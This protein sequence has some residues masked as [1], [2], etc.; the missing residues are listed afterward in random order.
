M[1]LSQHPPVAGHHG[2][3]AGQAHTVSA[4]HVPEDSPEWRAAQL[5]GRRAERRVL[6]RLIEAVRAGESRAL[7]LHGEAGVGKTALLEYLAAQA[8]GCRIARTVNVQSEMELAFAGLH[9]LCAPMLD[10]LEHLPVP[11]RDALRTAFGMSPGPA[12]DR[13]LVGLAV[14]S[15][16]SEVAEQQPLVCLVD[17]GQWLDHASAQILAFVARRLGAESIGLVFAER[18]RGGDLAGLPEL[19]VGGLQEADARALLDSALTG[20]LDARVRDQIIA[21][22]G[23]NPLA[24]LELPRGLTVA[25][26]AG[27]FGFPGAVPLAGS[28]EASFR[29]RSDALPADSRRLLLLAAADPTGDSALLWRAAERLGIGGEAAA[30]AAEAGLAEF[31]VRVRFR[32]PLVRSAA[33]RSASTQERQQ[34]HRALAEATDPQLDP[35]RRAWHRAQAAPG[36]DEDVAGELERSAG[37][38]RARGGLAAA[39][40]FL[41]R[42]ATLTLDPA[43]RAGRALAAAQAKLQAGVLDVVRDLLAMAETGPLSDFQQAHLDL[44]WAQ[45][46]LITRR[47]GDAPALLLKAAS[48]LA[49]IDADL[50]RATYLD[51]LFAAISAGRLASPGGGILEVARAAGAAP[52]PPHAPRAPDLLLDGLAAEYNQGYAAAVP[53]LRSALTAYAAGMS[54]DEELH[55]LWLAAVVA[56]RLWDY[57]RWDVLSVRHVQLARETGALSELPLALTSRAYVLLF[58]GELTAAASLIEEVQAVKEATGTGLAPYGPLGLAALRGDEAETLALIDATMQDVTRRGE[59]EGITFA[60]WADAV[61]SNGLG[62]YAKAAAAARRACSFDDDLGSLVWVTPELTEAAARTGMTEAAAWACDRLEEMTSASGT[63]WGLGIGAR[64]RALVSEG[65]EAERLYRESIARLGRTRLR[66]DL[67][68]AQLLYGEWLRRERRPSEAR[69]QLRTAH[70]MLEAMGIAAFAERARRELRAAGGTVHKRT[71]AASH[72]ELT[73]QEAQI[74]RLARDGLSN[75]EIGTRLFISARTV[76]YHLRKVFTKLG[77]TSRSQLDRVLPSGPAAVHRPR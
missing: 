68:R 27:G 75:P 71:A 69:E 29:W 1:G 66:V 5:T 35:D 10:R 20:P 2:Q 67:A 31:G 45:L 32:H 59:G 9:Q 30:P 14:L 34:V 58:A 3:C 77:I 49:P 7:V 24:L 47:G 50:S 4:M 33:Y 70:H 60:E 12:P 25:E 61:L 64:S 42:A 22:T 44:M 11:Q 72:E 57:D 43:Q 23:G 21:E 63:D 51:A 36:P 39:A 56:L 38:A 53:I 76:Q 41:E 73:A 15:L 55:W 17:D 16:L 8:P 62:K 6:D 26:L 54:A 65:Q 74:A 13:F 19:A 46:A 40:A 52:A 37:R 18:T 48:R 28:I